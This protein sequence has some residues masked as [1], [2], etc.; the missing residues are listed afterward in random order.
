MRD[1]ALDPTYL[2]ERDGG[3]LV[4]GIHVDGSIVFFLSDVGF[5]S[6]PLVVRGFILEVVGR[7]GGT[8]YIGVE[9]LGSRFVGGEDDVG[10]VR[11]GR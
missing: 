3:L 9:I 8:T 6:S 4:N 1:A 10:L 5:F 2:V 7:A 11:K